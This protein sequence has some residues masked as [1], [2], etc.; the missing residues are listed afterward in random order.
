M[1]VGHH[2]CRACVRT[3]QGIAA[4][5]VNFELIENLKKNYVRQ[6]LIQLTKKLVLG[7]VFAPKLSEKA[8]MYI[9]YPI[10]LYVRKKRTLGPKGKQTL[11][12]KQMDI[13]QIIGSV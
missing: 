3:V 10:I 4:A 8:K 9:E 2:H 1:Y 13:R 11:Y 5:F 6:K 7:D 12:F